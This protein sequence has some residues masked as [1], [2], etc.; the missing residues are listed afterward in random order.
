M[1]SLKLHVSV[2]S[3]SVLIIKSPDYDYLM[4]VIMQVSVW[5]LL[6]KGSFNYSVVGLGVEKLE[7]SVCR[8][9]QP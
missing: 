4:N 3:A 9:R 2:S 5:R 7:L 8:P 6:Q 1:R